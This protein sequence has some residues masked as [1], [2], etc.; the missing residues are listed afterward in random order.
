MEYLKNHAK[1][2]DTEYKKLISISINSFKLDSANG[3]SADKAID[4]IRRLIHSE[5]IE[6]NFIYKYNQ[7]FEEVYRIYTLSFSNYD[8][9]KVDVVESVLKKET[10]EQFKDKLRIEKIPNF[11]YDEDFINIK[12]ED[13]VEHLLKYDVYQKCYSRLSANTH[14]YKLFYQTE[15]YKKF[16]FEAFG[17]HVINSK[18]YRDLYSIS[19][20]GEPIPI[21]VKRINEY[22]NIVYDIDNSNEINH[23]LSNPKKKDE[24]KKQIFELDEQLLVLHLCLEDKNSIPLTEKSKLIILIDKIIEDNLFKLPSSDSKTYSKISKGFYRKGSKKTM[25]EIIDS[26]LT[27][28]ENY[29]LNI[30][31]Q[32]LKKHKA[33]LRKEQNNT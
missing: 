16:T 15:N 9:K 26:I 18:L 4:N 2:T 23:Q 25:I 19:Y 1:I 29:N 17:D 6:S 33:I 14:L 5:F 32:T 11:T 20:P 21:A 12:Y 8:S 22:Q 30:T 10:N 13:F 24:I 7:H 27:K 31:N 3:I 28:I